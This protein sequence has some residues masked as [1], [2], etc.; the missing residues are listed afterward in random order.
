MAG[1]PIP[2]SSPRPSSPA[3][4]AA[5]QFGSPSVPQIPLPASHAATPTYGSPR[6]AQGGLFPLLAARPPPQSISSSDSVPSNAAAT[7]TG[8]PTLLHSS[9]R[10]DSLLPSADPSTLTDAQK[11]AIVRK[12]LLSAED[13]RTVAAESAVVLGSSPGRSQ[14][15]GAA[16]TD[17]DASSVAVG[18]DEDYPTPYNMQGGDIVAPI[19]KWAAQQSGSG[20]SGQGTP[21]LRRSKSL[22]SVNLPSSRRVSRGEYDSVAPAGL[23][24]GEDNDSEM[25]VREILE[26][27]GAFFPLL[28]QGC[29]LILLSLT[30][31]RRD[32]VIRRMA[33]RGEDGNGAPGGRFTRSFVDFL[34][35]YG[36]FGGE[37]LEEI[38]EEE[39]DEEDE[40]EYDD[41]HIIPQYQGGVRSMKAGTR[42]VDGDVSERAPLFRRPTNRTTRSSADTRG[43]SRKR[44]SSVGQSGDATVTQAVLM[45]L[46]SFVGTGVLFLGKACVP[47]SFFCARIPPDQAPT[48]STTEGLS[49]RPSSCASS[50]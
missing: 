27:G 23:E 35:L 29:P 44:S 1:L 8:R 33:S 43:A 14:W 13:Q 7:S 21:S 4:F 9:G 11:A 42:E 20:G 49:F 41:S 38:D 48:G 2:G 12:H 40:L 16:V 31:F 26:P 3:A 6:S 34:S 10:P 50:R 32:F 17:D 39:E 15:G 19:Y 18:G 45:L 28:V 46:K 30:G 36:H 5:T 47:I 22:V 37:D 24:D 25:G